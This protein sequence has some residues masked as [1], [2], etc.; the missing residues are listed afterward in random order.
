MSVL[1]QKELELLLLVGFGHGIAL[2]SHTS[3]AEN[4][5]MEPRRLFVNLAPTL[6]CAALGLQAPHSL[7]FAFMFRSSSVKE[8]RSPSVRT[9]CRGSVRRPITKAYV[10][11]Q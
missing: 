8:G 7:G 10:Y 1:W 4:L 5:K 3:Q 6:S 2:L 9:L 11:F